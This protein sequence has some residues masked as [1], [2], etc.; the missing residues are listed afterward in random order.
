MVTELACKLIRGG[1]SLIDVNGK[2]QDAYYC[3]GLLNTIFSGANTY[4]IKRIEA[5]YIGD[6]ASLNQAIRRWYNNND[7]PDNAF[8][9]AYSKYMDGEYTE[10]LFELIHSFSNLKLS[11]APYILENDIRLSDVEDATKFLPDTVLVTLVESI[12]LNKDLHVCN[13]DMIFKGRTLSGWLRYCDKNGQLKFE[14]YVCSDNCNPILVLKY[15][16]LL[17]FDGES[18]GVYTSNHSNSCLYKGVKIPREIWRL[19]H[20]EFVNAMFC[21]L[22]VS[23]ACRSTLFVNLLESNYFMVNE[24][25]LSVLKFWCIGSESCDLLGLF[26]SSMNST[27]D[28]IP[29]NYRLAKSQLSEYSRIRIDTMWSGAYEVSCGDRTRTVYYDFSKIIESE[30]IPD[31]I[32]NEMIDYA[33]PTVF[34]CGAL[35]ISGIMLDSTGSYSIYRDSVLFSGY[36]DKLNVIETTKDLPWESRRNNK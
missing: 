15:N 8:K 14:P 32:Y 29:M 31:T 7:L 17:M 33:V 10:C 23:V 25:M 1:I 30:G 24:F 36:N 19:K 20:Y 18:W 3:T 27:F 13:K 28:V 35:A 5:S 11:D 2:S 21:C 26:R 22:L 34:I 4:S 9:R 12:L 6:L 16:R